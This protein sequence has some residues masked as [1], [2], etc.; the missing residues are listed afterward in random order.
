MCILQSAMLEI[1][2]DL[3]AHV[4]YLITEMPELHTGVD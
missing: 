3:I 4:T 2:M 1:W